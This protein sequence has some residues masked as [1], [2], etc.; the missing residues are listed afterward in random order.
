[1]RPSTYLAALRHYLAR[2]Y[3]YSQARILARAVA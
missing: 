1:M 2:G 3:L